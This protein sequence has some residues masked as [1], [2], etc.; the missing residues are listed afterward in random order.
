[1]QKKTQ[2][3]LDTRVIDTLTMLFL[4]HEFNL[5][6]ESYGNKIKGGINEL[7]NRQTVNS[8]KALIKN[9]LCE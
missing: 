2:V 4:K 9:A 8:Q 5:S 1:M 7:T 6:L 3:S